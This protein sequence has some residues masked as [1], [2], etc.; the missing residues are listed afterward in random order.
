MRALKTGQL[1]HIHSI[2]YQNARKFIR[3]LDYINQVLSKSKLVKVGSQFCFSFTVLWSQIQCLMVLAPRKPS[4]LLRGTYNKGGGNSEDADDGGNGQ[5]GDDDLCAT[6]FR[7]ATSWNQLRKGADL[8]M[9]LVNY[10]HS[11]VKL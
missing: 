6:D 1:F 2:H 9:L 11:I 8:A 4:L 7:S 5:E 10:N 3:K